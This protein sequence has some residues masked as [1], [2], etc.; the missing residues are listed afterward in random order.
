MAFHTY[1]KGT[2]DI[3]YTFNPG[4]AFQLEEF[5]LHLESAGGANNF[6]ATL[7]SAEGS[8]HDIVLNTQDMTSATDEQYQ[9][10]RPLP[11]RAGDT[12]RFEW[13][14]DSSIQWGL[15]IVTN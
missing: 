14:N 3:A 7:L 12:I 5:R 1:Q 10:T 2:T 6:T 8:E 15:E 9:P 13:S 4:K 11:F